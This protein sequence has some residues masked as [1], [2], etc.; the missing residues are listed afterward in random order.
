MEPGGVTHLPEPV[1]PT[2][3][4]RVHK[5]EPTNRS[6]NVQYQP[7]PHTFPDGAR[8]VLERYKPSRYANSQSENPKYFLGFPS[9]AG[10]IRTDDLVTPSHARYQAA[11]QPVHGKSPKKSPVEPPRSG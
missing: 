10:R 6:H 11:P 5:V 9:R 2:N 4:S 7:K 8:L 1:S 3:R